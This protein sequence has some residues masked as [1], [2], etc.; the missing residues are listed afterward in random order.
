MFGLGKTTA[1]SAALIVELRANGTYLISKDSRISAK[2][3]NLLREGIDAFLFVR[4]CDV[5]AIG[6]SR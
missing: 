3:Y 5:E 4:A 6:N 2:E 1:R